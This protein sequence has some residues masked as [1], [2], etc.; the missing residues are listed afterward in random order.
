[1]RPRIRQQHDVL[2]DD[3]AELLYGPASMDEPATAI[4]S[5][6]DSTKN[7]ISG[8]PTGTGA[9]VPKPWR[10][11]RRPLLAVLLL[12]ATSVG[13]FLRISIICS[14][15]TDRIDRGPAVRERERKSRLRISIRRN[16]GVSDK[17]SVPGPGNLGKGAKFGVY[18]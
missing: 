14:G 17:Q 16:H 10:P 2:S 8:L 3:G 11:S 4:L 15:E 13:A 18:L 12:V 6:P 5:G 1:M 9:L 7:E